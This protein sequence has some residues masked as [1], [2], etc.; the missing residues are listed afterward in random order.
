M[1]IRNF[2]PTPTYD[3]DSEGAGGGSNDADPLLNS[4]GL[5]DSIDASG[6]ADDP[7]VD[8]S[9]TGSPQQS[10]TGS[11]PDSLRTEQGQAGKP[12]TA[13][14][15]TDPSAQ[16]QPGAKQFRAAQ[17]GSII[18]GEGKVVAKA[19][20]ERRLWEKA[21]NYENNIVPQMQTALQ[22][23]QQQ[24]Q[25][26]QGQVA[27][28]ERAGGIGKELG[29]SGDQVIMGANLMASYIKDPVATIKYILTEAKA[30]G[31]NVDGVISGGVDTGVIQKMIQDA[32]GPLTSHH[33][34]QQADAKATED[35]RNEVTN[36]LR[37]NPDAVVHEP[38]IARLLERY[39]TLSMLEAKLLLE[40]HYLQNGLD[41][42]KPYDG[43]QVQGNSQVSNPGQLPHGRPG[44]DI[45]STNEPHVMSEDAEIGDIVKSAM[46]DAGMNV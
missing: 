45:V 2:Y 44:G 28:F 5:Q 34:Q 9:Q 27:G 33:E 6:G 19:G 7:T 35:I 17:D 1:T 10:Q 22:Q 26:L 11:V 36:F 40:R 15:Q 46:K 20:A 14:P 32:V 24:L 4:T 12:G 37:T 3:K 31:H 41:W 29:L 43:T 38:E 18:D 13:G 8:P 39:P 42:S 30:A 23:A 16:P 25:T 21:Y